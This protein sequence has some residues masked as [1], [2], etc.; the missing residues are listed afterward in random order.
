M[1]DCPVLDLNR[2]ISR[3]EYASQRNGRVA[4]DGALAEIPAAANAGKE[5]RQMRIANYVS[6]SLSK[7]QV[8]RKDLP[9]HICHARTV[10]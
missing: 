7:Y 10:I 8:T 2:P 6:L 5:L 3:P 9:W 1:N 4:S